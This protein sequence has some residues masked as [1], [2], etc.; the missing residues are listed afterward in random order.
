MCGGFCVSFTIVIAIFDDF[1][2]FIFSLHNF[3][4]ILYSDLE[5]PATKYDT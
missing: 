3:T 4:S 1:S 5:V 2:N